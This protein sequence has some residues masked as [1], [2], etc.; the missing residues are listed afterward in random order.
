[1]EHASVT[2]T[3]WICGHTIRERRCCFYTRGSSQKNISKQLLSLLSSCTSKASPNSKVSAEK[4]P[5]LCPTGPA[6]SARHTLVS[7]RDQRW[8]PSLAEEGRWCPAIT[9]PRPPAPALQLLHRPLPDPKTMKR[10]LN[11]QRSPGPML[12]RNSALPGRRGSAVPEHRPMNT[13]ITAGF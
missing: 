9:R 8:S 4:L 7:A 10:P 6:E 5:Q 1:M 3:K 11:P 13:A 2:E 12:W